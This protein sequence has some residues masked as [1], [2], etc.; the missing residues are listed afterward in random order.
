M[1]ASFLYS[2]SCCCDNKFSN[3][4]QGEN[5]I[6]IQQASNFLINTRSKGWAN[7][8][9]KTPLGS[10][11]FFRNGEQIKKSKWTWKKSECAMKPESKLKFVKKH[12]SY[13]VV[14]VS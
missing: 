8:E 1:K 3:L 5:N 10:A 7:F 2:N 4:F 13:K 12:N 14:S 6:L 9:G 11:T